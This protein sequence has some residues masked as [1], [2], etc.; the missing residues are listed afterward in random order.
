MDLFIQNCCELFMG[1]FPFVTK[2]FMSEL[3]DLIGGLLFFGF[4]VG[5]IAF[6]VWCDD[7]GYGGG[8]R[9]SGIAK[10]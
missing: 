2:Y 4:V 1:K 5:F 6:L 8:D 7:E 10:F 3:L 9:R